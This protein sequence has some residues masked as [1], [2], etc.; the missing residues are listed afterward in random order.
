MN[1]LE[2]LS[3]DLEIRRSRLQQAMQAMNI[4]A[5]VLTTVVNVFYMTGKVY[6]GY[7]YLPAEGK[8]VHFV[9]R[10]EGI[11]FE[12]TI[13]VRKPEQITDELQNLGLAH[14]KTLL[15][16]TDV[17]PYGECSRLL[18][19][20]ELT[21]AANA[22][23]LLRRLRSVKTD[24]ELEQI[25][26]CARCHEA[27]YKLIPSLYRKDMTDV[28][29]QIE[30]EKVMR[31]HGSLGL[32]R[33]YGENMDIYMGSLLVGENAEVPSPFDF[34]LGGA[35]TTPIIPLGASG[36]KIKD[37][38]TIMVDMAGNYTP[39]MTDMTRV[40]SA[41]K[42]L[43]IAYDAHQVSIDIHNHIMD[44]AKPGVSCAEL[45]NISMEMV[46]KHNLEPY[47][48][49]TKQQAKFVGHG[50]GLEINEPPVL[51]PRS[52]EILEPNI[53]FALEPKFVIPEVGAVGI[54]NTYL[55]TG[56]GIEKLTILEE[57][58]VEL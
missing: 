55:I 14:P 11:D 6:N 13:Y 2:A 47:F 40:F 5:C 24:F 28:E 31:Q 57:N 12:N 58:I 23:V 51:T 49:G 36:Q 29:L 33:S 1:Y 50:V 54:E 20:F 7:F 43:D 35:G 26:L 19:T 44:I 27:V 21:E 38:Q 8:P 41:G 3:N 22:S 56:D 10:P 17:I 15:L 46:K 34:A 48:M 42:T 32:F 37:G 16:E 9:K 18:G 4:E 25:R 52:K 53:V 30:I 39:W 45:Y